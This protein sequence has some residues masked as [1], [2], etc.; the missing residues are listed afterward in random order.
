MG[1]KE[2]IAQYIEFSPDSRGPGYARLKD[3]GISIWALIGY[4]TQATKGDIERVAQDY[5]VPLEAVKAAVAFYKLHT[6][7]IDARLI[8]SSDD[9]RLHAA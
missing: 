4:L 8:N 5:D 6:E 3:S 7:A 9:T 1:D 2:L